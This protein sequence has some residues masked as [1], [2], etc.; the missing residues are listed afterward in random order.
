[1][2]LVTAP[3]GLRQLIA[4]D[5]LK[6]QGWPGK[7]TLANSEPYDDIEKAAWKAQGLGGHTDSYAQQVCGLH[8]FRAL[9]GYCHLFRNLRFCFLKKV[10][11]SRLK[12]QLS[13]NKS[14]RIRSLYVGGCTSTGKWDKIRAPAMYR[15]G[16]KFPTCTTLKDDHKATT[17]DQEGRKR[18]VILHTD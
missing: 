7:L 5:L 2:P 10:L 8:G 11:H 1:M 16:R 15:S 18:S 13:P 4:K 3:F 6:Q 14:M 9:C 17:N 12:K